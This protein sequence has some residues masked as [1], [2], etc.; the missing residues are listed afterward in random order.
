[1]HKAN[2][3]KQSAEKYGSFCEDGE[4]A[5]SQSAASKTNERRTKKGKCIN[6]KRKTAGK[7]I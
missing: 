7:I 2:C 4:S 6:G 1:M 5:A 3:S